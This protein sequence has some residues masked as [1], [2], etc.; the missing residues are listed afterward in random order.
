MMNMNDLAAAIAASL[1]E[2][3][4]PVDPLADSNNDGDDGNFEYTADLTPEE[5]ASV[6]AYVAMGF[7]YP[8]NRNH[9]LAMYNREIAIQIGGVDRLPSLLDSKH[10]LRSLFV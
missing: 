3:L 1:A 6:F 7:M 9:E 8:Q 10:P 5:A 2:A 4:Q